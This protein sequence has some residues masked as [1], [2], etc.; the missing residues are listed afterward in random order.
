MNELNINLNSAIDQTEYKGL[1][2]KDTKLS[3]AY[4]SSK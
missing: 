3:F 4:Q 2:M 1:I